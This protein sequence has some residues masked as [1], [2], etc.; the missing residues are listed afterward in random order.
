MTTSEHQIEQLPEEMIF[1]ILTWMSNKDVARCKCIHTTWNKI[2]IG[3]DQ[4]KKLHFERGVK[5]SIDREILRYVKNRYINGV[6]LL[7][8][9]EVDAYAAIEED[10]LTYL[11]RNKSKLRQDL[12]QGLQDALPTG[13]EKAQSIGKRVILS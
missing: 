3:D 5:L 6:Q 1:E 12:Y 2:I 4:F 8:Q 7:Q 9:Y 13:D 11:K 10:R